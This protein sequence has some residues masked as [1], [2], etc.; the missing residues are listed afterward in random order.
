MIIVEPS[1]M[2]RG[3]A[4]VIPWRGVVPA[5]VKLEASGPQ[6]MRQAQYAL[7]I[8][9]V[10]M[11]ILGTQIEDKPEHKIVLCVLRI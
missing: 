7:K 1:G 3:T 6:Q 8:T 9:L 2:F 5:A 11:G 4:T 10:R